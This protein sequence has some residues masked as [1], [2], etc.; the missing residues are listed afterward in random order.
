[1]KELLL[2]LVDKDTLYSCETHW[3]FLD[4]ISWLR[5]HM[6]MSFFI[7]VSIFSKTNTKRIERNMIFWRRVIRPQ[8][9]SLASM[10]TC[11]TNSWYFVCLLVR[12][13][14]NIRTYWRSFKLSP[15]RTSII[16]DSYMGWNDTL[17][18]FWH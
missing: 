16:W 9:L 8:H 14:S 18:S 15:F 2:R 1:M 3:L 12:R 7:L 10:M 13:I 5:M 6:N 4:S 11:R 17:K